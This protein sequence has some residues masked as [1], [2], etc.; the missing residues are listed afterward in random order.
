MGEEWGEEEVMIRFDE[1]H[2]EYVDDGGRL[3]PSV[4]TIIR[5]AGL[6]HIEF[7][8]HDALERGSAVHDLTAR[9]DRKELDE[10]KIQPVYAGY[11]AAWI[12]FRRD[13]GFTPTAIEKPVENTI[14]GFAGTLDRLGRFKGSRISKVISRRAIVEIKTNSCPAW[15]PLQLA[16][17]A[18]CLDSPYSWDRFVVVLMSNGDYRFNPKDVSSVEHVLA[19]NNLVSFRNYCR[20]YNV[21]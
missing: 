11:L 19:F 4:S 2:H 5:E 15:T 18:L 21:A 6:G 20:K 9:Y 1:V 10:R 3:I 13:C 16:G 17:Y 12:A 7:V 8:P 14:L